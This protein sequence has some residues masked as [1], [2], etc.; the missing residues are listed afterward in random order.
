MTIRHGNV[1]TYSP[2]AFCSALCAAFLVAIAPQSF[3]QTT[4]PGSVDPGRLQQNT[5][6]APVAPAPSAPMLSIPEEPLNTVLPKVKKGFVLKSVKLVGLTVLDEALFQDEFK[7]AIGQKANLE[8]LTV[9][10]NRATLLFREKGYFIS[11]FVVPEQTVADG[12]VTLAAVEG[13]AMDFDVRMEDSSPKE[14]AALES[15]V[16]EI[17]PKILA[18]GPLQRDEVQDILMRLNDLG[19]IAAGSVLEPLPADM[20]EPGAVKLVVLMQKIAPRISVGVDNNGSRFAGPIQLRTGATASPGIFNFDR[21]IANF[22]TT[23]PTREV[24]LGSLTYEA[25]VNYSGT[26]V[27]FN[28]GISRSRP[29]F[30]LQ[31]DDIVSDSV[32]FEPYVRHALMR[33]REMNLNLNASLDMRDIDSDISGTELFTDR[34]RSL[35]IGSDMTYTD[36]WGGSGGGQLRLS[37]G[38]DILDSRESGSRNLS[39]ARGRSDFTKLDASLNR[40]QQITQSWQIFANFS[41]QFTNDPLL[42]TE[43]FGVGGQSFG[44]AYDPSELLGDRGIAAA[45]ELRYGTLPPV[46]GA[47][48]VPFAFY[49]IGS[50]WNIDPGARNQESAA[51]AGVGARIWHPSGVSGSLGLAM[52]LTKD[53]TTPIFG[54]TARDPRLMFEMQYGF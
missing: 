48:F 23:A 53:V 20:A 15:I 40:L 18:L 35:R 13:Y 51:S 11:R 5:Q 16:R 43:E 22:L 42:S 3:A 26:F 39:R 9:L 1:K 14:Q 8:T 7:E 50:V 34:I 33:S 4:L 27:G 45:V 12:Q 25:P 54:N 30:T 24:K 32:S 10:S 6:Q 36:R 44:R 38:L 37:K 19:G 47:Y 17:K 49:D 46:L 31:A 52:P 21:L 41:G 2:R 29:G 28:A